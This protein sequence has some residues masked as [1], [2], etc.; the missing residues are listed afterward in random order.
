MLSD[1]EFITLEADDEEILTDSDEEA[2][3]ECYMP[4]N[5]AGSAAAVAIDAAWANICD[6]NNFLVKGP[7]YFSFPD[8]YQLVLPAE[9]DKKTDCPPGHIAIHAHMLDFGLRFRLDPFILKIF[10]VWNIYVV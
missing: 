1:E 6:E 7:I 10:K 9:G 5:E 3:A 8:D 4:P 2:L